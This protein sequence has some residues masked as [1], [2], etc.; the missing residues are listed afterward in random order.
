MIDCYFEQD[1]ICTNADCP[2][3]AD[4]CPVWE[5]VEICLFREPKIKEGSHDFANDK[6]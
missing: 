2:A 6:E 5:Y 3:R 1:E 4:Y